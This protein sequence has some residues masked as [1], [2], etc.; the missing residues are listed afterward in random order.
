MLNSIYRGSW[1]ETETGPKYSNVVSAEN[2]TVAE[3]YMLFRPIPKPKIN[4]AEYIT[5]VSA[6]IHM[7]GEFANEATRPLAYRTVHRHVVPPRSEHTF[8]ADRQT[9]RGWPRPSRYLGHA[10]HG[11]CA[12]DGQIQI[13]I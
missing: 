6:T 2:E 9:S 12:S 8:L 1:S 13:M 4:N 10:S 7:H 11:P 5:Y 3:Y